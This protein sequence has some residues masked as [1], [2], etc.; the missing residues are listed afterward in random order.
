MTDNLED[1]ALTEFRA[2]RDKAQ[3]IYQQ[4]QSEFERTHNGQ[5]VC[6][7]GIETDTP[8][9][10][11]GKTD[12]D[13]SYLARREHLQGKLYTKGINKPPEAHALSPLKI[14]YS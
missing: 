4:H 7:A 3:A 13:A 12:K 10:Y 1:K 9:F 2:F 5:Y 11:F 14:H 6:I 8:Q